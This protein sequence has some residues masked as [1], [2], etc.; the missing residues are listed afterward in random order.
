[1]YRG[2]PRLCYSSIQRVEAKS[3]I[4]QCDMISFKNSVE[5]IAN[6]F[7]DHNYCKRKVYTKEIKHNTTNT[8]LQL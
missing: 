8:K 6:I 3:S 4:R 1:M 7:N 5:I 2:S